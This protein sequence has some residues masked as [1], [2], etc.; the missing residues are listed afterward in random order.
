MK[1]FDDEI[2]MFIDG[3][4]GDEM[5]EELFAHLTG[6]DECQNTLTELLLL[7]ATS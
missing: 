6:C 7:K 3:E 5:R 1:H 4:L 2:N